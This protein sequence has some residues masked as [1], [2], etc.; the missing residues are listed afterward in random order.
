MFDDLTDDELKARITSYRDALEKLAMGGVVTVIAGEG[1]RKEITRGNSA[2]LRALLAEAR[3]ALDRR[4][5]N[6]RLPGRA[7]GV[8]FFN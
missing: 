3:D 8:R 2:D 5:N 1:R 7:L 4:N 6:G